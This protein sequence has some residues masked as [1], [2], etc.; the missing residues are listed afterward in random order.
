MLSMRYNY[1]LLVLI[2]YAMARDLSSLSFQIA[3]HYNFLGG[4]DILYVRFICAAAAARSLQTC[5]QLGRVFII[6]ENSRMTPGTSMCWGHISAQAP[7]P[8]QAVG[9]FS[10]GMLSRRILTVKAEANFAS[11]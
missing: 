9:S 6:S 2:L 10:F 3:G 7:Q 11:L 5:A 8:T 1:S 4:A